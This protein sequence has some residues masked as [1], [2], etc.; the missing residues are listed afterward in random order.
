MDVPFLGGAKVINES[1]VHSG[2][3]LNSSSNDDLNTMYFMSVG[4]D[5]DGDEMNDDG[6]G[7]ETNN[8]CISQHF[9]QNLF[10]VPVKYIL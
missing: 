6:L 9:S 1:A 3:V 5:D 8:T 2:H 7:S 4:D 10:E